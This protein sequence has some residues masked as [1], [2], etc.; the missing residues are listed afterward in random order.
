[1]KNNLLLA[2][3]FGLMLLFSGCNQN[4]VFEK[5]TDFESVSW[6][7]NSVQEFK[8]DIT[9][10]SKKYDVF[11]NVRN[12]LQYEYYNLYLKHTL[13]GPDGKPISSLLHEMILM[14]K[15]TGKPLGDGAGDIFDHR[16]LAL[17]NQTFASPGTYTIKLQQYMRRDPLPGI[18]AV[19]V[20]VDEVKP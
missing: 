2:G 8:F 13:I 9:D 19:G 10:T 20:R 1:M 15:K 6:P 17:K 18:M 12:A 5:N 14:D 16:F 3:F 4:R 11:F 7:I